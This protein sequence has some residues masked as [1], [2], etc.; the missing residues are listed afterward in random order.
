[1]ITF[2]TE[3]FGVYDAVVGRMIRLISWNC[4]LIVSVAGMKLITVKKHI[5]R[6]I[7]TLTMKHKLLILV[8][9]SV[10]HL[11]SYIYMDVLFLYARNVTN[12]MN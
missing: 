11:K 12:V 1:M 6:I 9:N 2:R 8:H 5:N 4:E 7:A 10:S 3:A